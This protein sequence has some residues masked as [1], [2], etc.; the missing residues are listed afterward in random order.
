MG[1]RPYLDLEIN[2][3]KDEKGRRSRIK[4]RVDEWEA[5]RKVGSSSKKESPKEEYD[6]ADMSDEDYTEI[7]RGAGEVGKK[8]HFGAAV[9]EEERKRLEHA[10]ALAKKRHRKQVRTKNYRAYLE[11][12][13][14]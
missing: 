1:D 2:N 8:L 12:N 4:N 5:R 3:F 14:Y 9:T 10:Q 13:E 11:D 6:E 7:W